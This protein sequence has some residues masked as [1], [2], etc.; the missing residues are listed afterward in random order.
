MYLDIDDEDSLSERFVSSKTIGLVDIAVIKLPRISNFTDF[1]SLEHMEGVSLRYI[2]NVSDLKETD[3]III[4][5]TKS[6]MADASLDAAEW[7]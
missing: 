2:T 3:M 4:P 1:N 7:S 5:G 6:T